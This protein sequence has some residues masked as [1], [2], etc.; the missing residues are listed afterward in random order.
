MG[1]YIEFRYTSDLIYYGN[2]IT[3]KDYVVTGK[4]KLL[5]HTKNSA[6]IYSHMLIKK[7]KWQAPA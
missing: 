7:S 2:S 1:F 6:P 4:L 5:T 3:V